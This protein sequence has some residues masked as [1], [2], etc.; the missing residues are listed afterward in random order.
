MEEDEEAVCHFPPLLG[1]L[2]YRT[3][4]KSGRGILHVL[5]LAIPCVF[6]QV[7]LPFRSQLS[8]LC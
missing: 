2:M 6:S 7:G 1:G 4:H 3:E 5:I 8:F